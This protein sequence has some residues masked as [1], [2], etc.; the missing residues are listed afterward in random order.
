MNAMTEMQQ[1]TNATELLTHDHR[2]VENI[3]ISLQALKGSKD[4][5]ANTP[6]ADFI[7]L[8]QNLTLHALAEEN[9]FYPELKNFPETASL[10]PEAYT[11]HQEVK[12]MLAQMRGLSPNSDDFQSLLAQLKAD[13]QHHVAEEENEMF[14]KARQVLGEQRLEELGR[15]IKQFKDR[16]KQNMSG[17]MSASATG[18]STM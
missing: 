6:N 12:D 16:E 18:S 4:S 9:I 17:G 5:S 15:Q 14:V 2:E 8:D 1:P 13:L 7:Q 10:V 3:I 11:E